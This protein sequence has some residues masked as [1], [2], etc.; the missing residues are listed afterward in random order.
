MKTMD[1]DMAGPRF[2]KRGAKKASVLRKRMPNKLLPSSDSSTE[3][4]E[5]RPIKRQKKSLG[6]TANPSG[7]KKDRDL[8]SAQTTKISADRSTFIERNDDATKQSHW[9]DSP[10]PQQ[11]GKVGLQE[12]PNNTESKQLGPMKAPA[13][14]RSIITTD[15]SPD[16]CKD[17]KTTGFCGFGDSCKF[18]HSRESYKQGWQL[19]REW[20]TVTQG[21]KIPGQV[22]SS[23]QKDDSFDQMNVEAPTENIP[24]ACII[25]KESYKN[26]IITKCGHYFCEACALRR[27]KK[28][29]SCAACG[30]GTGGVFNGAKNLK[31]LLQ[32]KEERAARNGELE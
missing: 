9:N 25:C 17:Y 10:M 3:E 16:V 19:D 18:L 22:V 5:A 8:E 32:A 14:I 24:F 4:D 26:P 29:P 12:K 1:D 7:M 30:A 13:N 15:Y 6:I 31:K 23:R 27:Y 2:K 21:K 28:S 11:K 20:E